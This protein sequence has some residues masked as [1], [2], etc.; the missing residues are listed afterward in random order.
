MGEG[1]TEEAPWAGS[2]CFEAVKTPRSPGGR[3]A[4]GAFQLEGLSRWL[5]CSCFLGPSRAGTTPSLPTKQKTA[6]T[7]PLLSSVR[8]FTSS[9]LQG[10]NKAGAGRAG[11]HRALHQQPRNMGKV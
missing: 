9:M 2:R 3:E 7:D 5:L 6:S 4:T 1:D 11:R 8:H 10:E